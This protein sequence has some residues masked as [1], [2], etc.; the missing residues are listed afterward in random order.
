MARRGQAAIVDR[1]GSSAAAHTLVASAKL[2]VASTKASEPA[3][4]PALGT[5]EGFPYAGRPG[6]DLADLPVEMSVRDTS[7]LEAHAPRPGDVV[8]GKY[9]VERV[10]GSGGMGVVVA[11]RHVHLGERVALKFL[12]TSTDESFV[13]RFLR[14]AQLAVRIKS[15]HVGRVLDVGT[16]DDG[17]P[18]M[19]MELLEGSDLDQLLRAHGPAGVD[20]TL[21]YVLQ[22]CEAVAEAH[23]LGIVHRDLKPANLFLTRRADG[24]PLVKVLDFG[25]SKLLGE[26]RGP[27]DRSLTRADDMLGSPQYMAPEQVRD[28][29]NVDA[30]CDIFSLGSILYKMLTGQPAFEGANPA[31]VLAMVLSEPP[32]PLREHRPEIPPTLEALVLACLEKD[33][34]A[35]VP[36]VEVL[37]RGLVPFAL[38]RPRRLWGDPVVLAPPPAPV[39]A[40]AMPATTLSTHVLENADGGQRQRRTLVA[41]GAG[42]VLVTL[43]AAISILTWDRGHAATGSMSVT[44]SAVTLSPSSSG[45]IASAPIASAPAPTASDRPAIE[46]PTAP[47]ISAAPSAS[48]PPR[49]PVSKPKGGKVVDPLEDRQ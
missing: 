36:S 38:P 26:F 30:R 35:R 39:A 6:F 28:P 34:A 25:I 37:A 3:F 13:A 27:T 22:A 10:I 16:L 33:P 18:Y 5:T 45:S 12:H 48:A 15:E 2:V 8:A 9:V 1:A 7:H 31:T 17:S 4:G 32:K 49:L 29:R 42:V 41:A 24:S 21:D 46:A 14:E 20:V 43:G 11:A 40:P 23:S 44:S 19:V 47:A